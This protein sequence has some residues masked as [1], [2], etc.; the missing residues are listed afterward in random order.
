MKR[1]EDYITEIT[2]IT[3][4]TLISFRCDYAS[5]CILKGD[6]GRQFKTII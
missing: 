4:S 6:E 2:E 3:E 5:I 1:Q